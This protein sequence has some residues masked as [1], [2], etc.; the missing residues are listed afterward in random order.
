MGIRWRWVVRPGWVAA[1]CLLAPIPS[2]AS[3]TAGVHFSPL[4]IGGVFSRCGRFFCAM[5][6]RDVSDAGEVVGGAGND[7]PA[8]T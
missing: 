3:A 5:E 4:S 1:A 6:A 8:A 7:V 2:T